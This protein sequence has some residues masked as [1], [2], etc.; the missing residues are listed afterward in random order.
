MI[1]SSEGKT[2]KTCENLEFS[3]ALHINL[4]LLP[5]FFHYSLIFPFEFWS[6]FEFFELWLL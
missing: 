4:Q 6:Y 1:Q 3:N 5:Y 2:R